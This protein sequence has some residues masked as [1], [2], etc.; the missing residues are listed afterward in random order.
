MFKAVQGADVSQFDEETRRLYARR[1]SDWR[2]SDY[3]L[4]MPRTTR[5]YLP[6]IVSDDHPFKKQKEAYLSSIPLKVA[7]FT[8]FFAYASWQF[9]KAFYPYGIVLRR[10]IPTTP[11]LQLSYRAPMAMVF[12]FLWYMQRE[13]PRS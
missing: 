11:A 13:Y 4:R 6:V 1:E 7:T 8:T 3:L 9:S 12:A 2:A 10:S 5:N